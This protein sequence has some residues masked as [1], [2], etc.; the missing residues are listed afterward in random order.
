MPIV[1]DHLWTGLLLLLFI[2]LNELTWL[3]LE[4][5]FT[6]STL[7]SINGKLYL[8]VHYNC[9]QQRRVE[10]VQQ[11]RVT[12]ATSSDLVNSVAVGTESNF[13]IN[14]RKMEWKWDAIAHV[15]F[16][17]L[18]FDRVNWLDWLGKHMW[19]DTSQNTGRKL[20]FFTAAPLVVR[21][22]TNS[23]FDS[24]NLGWDLSWKWNV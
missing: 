20:V 3:H 6:Q 8:C 18:A 19:R 16:G 15:L 5:F 14:G 11:G 23:L 10:A 24:S 21:R 17:S 22:R 13:H 7:I 2:I 12:M 4:Y 1:T 9:E